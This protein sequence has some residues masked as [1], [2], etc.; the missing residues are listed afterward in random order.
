VKGHDDKRQV[1]CHGGFARMTPATRLKQPMNTF[2]FVLCAI[3]VLVNSLLLFVTQMVAGK[4]Q[5]PWTGGSL[6]HLTTLAGRLAPTLGTFLALAICRIRHARIP[7]LFFL[8]WFTTFAFLPICLARGPADHVAWQWSVV[9]AVGSFLAAGNIVLLTLW[10]ASRDRS[11]GGTAVGS[12]FP[13]FLLAISYLG[14]LI[15]PALCVVFIEPFLAI[16]NQRLSLQIGLG[17]ALLLLWGCIVAGWKTRTLAAT[18]NVPPPGSPRPTLLARLQWVL[19]TA[20]PA[21]LATSFI[22]YISTEISPIP[23]FWIVPMAICSFTLV[24]AFVRLSSLSHAE[25]IWSM[26]LQAAGGLI[27]WGIVTVGYYLAGVYTPYFLPIATGAL[28]LLYLPHRF[29]LIL[30]PLVTIGAIY[31]CLTSS[32]VPT[33]SMIAFQLLA[34]WVNCWGCHGVLAQYRPH[35]AF[36][37][38]FLCCLAL[39]GLLA[40]ILNSVILPYIDMAVTTDYALLLAL[41]CVIRFTPTQSKPTASLRTAEQAC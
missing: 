22:V 34:L 6:D 41:A 7:T 39:G 29:T 35:P 8:V 36:L 19:L 16:D 11:H 4:I 37:P 18:P 38:G 33:W 31:L 12:P 28:T 27:C 24:L 40:G 26:G 13:Y 25:L 10:Y 20:V 21:S 14:S 9:A 32:D 17:I 30:Q 2:L 5:L 3:G 23:L 1:G 15:A